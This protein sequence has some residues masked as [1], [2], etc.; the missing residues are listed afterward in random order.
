M[1][2]RLR[3]DRSAQVTRDEAV[4]VLLE[5]RFETTFVFGKDGLISSNGSSRDGERAE[6]NRVDVVRLRV[7]EAE[8][9][10]D[11]LEERTTELGDG[12]SNF[13]RLFPPGGRDGTETSSNLLP[14]Y[15]MIQPASQS[16]L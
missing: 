14:D 5:E 1:T 3:E 2:N 12:V 15:E 7:L 11:G 13:L 10:D 6:F 4:V 16:S 9:V 8:T